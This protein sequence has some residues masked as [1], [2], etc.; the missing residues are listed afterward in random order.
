MVVR[1][2]TNVFQ[3][4]FSIYGEDCDKI[5]V[6]NHDELDEHIHRFFDNE[7]VKIC[8]AI[9]SVSEYQ[10]HVKEFLETNLGKDDKTNYWV[11]WKLARD[12]ENFRT[13]YKAV[14]VIKDNKYAA[15]FRMSFL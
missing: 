2:N 12:V 1:I 4:I 13:D 6:I 7:S 15:L 8:Q 3:T 9:L 5:F 10:P 11:H 14:F